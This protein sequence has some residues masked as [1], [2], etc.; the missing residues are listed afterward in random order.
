MEAIE[1]RCSVCD[2]GPVLRK[3]CA[4]CSPKASLLY[5]RELRREARAAGEPYWLEW[6]VK[7]YGEDAHARRRA[8][9]REYMRRYRSRHAAAGE[10][11]KSHG[12][13]W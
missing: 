10:R 4:G 1:V 5:K 12:S 9:Q 8:Y 13:N 7:T 11:G 6:W 2:K 3:Y